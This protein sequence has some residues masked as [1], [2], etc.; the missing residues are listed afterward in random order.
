MKSFSDIFSYI[1]SQETA[2]KLPIPINDAWKWSMY[3]HIRLTVLYKNSQF[4]NSTIDK[5]NTPFKN[6]M[7]PLLMLQYFAEGFDVKDIV[8]F[9]SDSAKYFKSFLVKKFHEEW[10]REN[11]IDTFIDELVESYVDFGGALVKNVNDIRP[12]VVPLQTIAFCDQTDILSGPIGIKHYYS[13]SQLMDMSEK[14]W[15]KRSSGA[16]ITLK[17]LILLS[18]E[19]KKQDRDTEVAQTPGK[20]IEVYEVHG[21][22]PKHFL[23]GREGYHYEPDEEFSPQLHIVCFYQKT[24]HTQ[25]GVTLFK[26]EEPKSPFKFI[27]RDPVFGRALGFGGAEEL[28]EA[29]VWVNFDELIMKDM[30]HEASKVVHITT[31][32]QF[33]TRNRIGGLVNGEVLELSPGTELKQMDTFPRSIQL[34]EKATRSWE[35]HGQKVSGVPNPLL[36]QE[37]TAGTPFKLQDLVVQT[38]KGPHEYRKG[39]LATFVDEI[40]MDW[41]MPKITKEITKGNEFLAELDMKE[42]NYVSDALVECEAQKKVK[43]QI[44]NGQM[45]DP[46]EIEGYKEIVRG[47]FSKRGNKHFIKILKGEMKDVPIKVK[48]NIAG[49]QKNLAGTVDKLVNIFR[50]VLANPQ[51]FM[52]IMQLPG[53]AEAWNDILEYSGLSPV[54]FSGIGKLQEQMQ[55]QTLPAQQPAMAEQNAY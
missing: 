53:M 49:K 23:N 11:K 17:D 38:G 32:P 21:Y 28:F 42:L 41:T 37:P 19:N 27:K 15:G 40:Y 44:L 29:Q 30:L 18:R 12:E 8:L 39:K 1:K 26:A 24:G 36:G 43:E 2:Y 14:G 3:Q 5:E 54:D 31:D 10:A 13:P 46:N 34:F 33:A 52:Q 50:F 6:I 9:I 20:Y 35:D 22:F 25:E 7:R 16:D 45:I 51:G 55:Q 47:E 4:S 48:T